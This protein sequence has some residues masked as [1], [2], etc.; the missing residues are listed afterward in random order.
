MKMK[1]SAITATVMLLALA[2]Q[3]VSAA[4]AVG[5][6][7]VTV[8]A[9]SDVLVSVPFNNDV[10]ATYTV[11]SVDGAG[12][13]VN[14]ALSADTYDSG[15]YVRVIDGAGEGLW[16]TITANG[17]GGLT[18]ADDFS[19]YVTNGDTFRVYEHHTIGSVLPDTLYGVAFTNSTQIQTYDSTGA[20][21]YKTASGVASYAAVP[22]LFNYQWTGSANAETILDPGSM[23]LIRN[24]AGDELALPLFG[25]VPD[26]NA[27][28]LV[29]A[30]ARDLNIGSG[31]P[32][33]MTIDELGIG[34]NNRQVQVY[35]N[36]ASGQFKTASGVATYAA[37]PPL[38]QYEWSGSA[39][40]DTEIV[41][42]QGFIVRLPT[43][44]VGGKIT[45]NRS[46]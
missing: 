32:V 13:T 35:D 11:D 43:G 28:V 8:P 26:H 17:S 38:F 22:P 40:G 19:G 12:V 45:I 30:G 4:E 29:E 15:Y 7:V 10:E 36:S 14:E 27:A 21:Q 24:G 18:L 1:T 25:D 3:T 46:Y 31:F 42:S 41:G 37:V 39:N 34:A 2:A 44:D 5:Y 6:N 9:N 23:F 16:S 33:A 20:G